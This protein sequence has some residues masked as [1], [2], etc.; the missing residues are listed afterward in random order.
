MGLSS[1]PVRLRPA[2][3][4]TAP[5]VAVAPAPALRALPVVPPP[6]KLVI[7][8]PPPPKPLVAASSGSALYQG[9]TTT[10][11]SSPVL[12]REEKIG[13]LAEMDENSVRP[14]TK[15]GLRKMCRQTVFGEGDPDAHLFFIGEG[16]GE[17][18]DK[19]GRPFVGP[20]GQKLD[21]MIGRMK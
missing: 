3:A 18:E 4:A 5:A 6:P 8:A 10:P 7:A 19:Q 16:P 1:L 13:A 2:S 15:C 17:Q 20:A 11:F 12:S 14:C 9:D 21:E